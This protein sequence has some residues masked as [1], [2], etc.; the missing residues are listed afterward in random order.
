MGLL[1]RSRHS[2][3]DV[4]ASRALGVVSLAIGLAEILFP[5]KIEQTMGIHNGENTG[6][7]RVLGV[8][9]IAHGIDLLAHD[10][11]TPGVVSRVA[12]DM[13]DGVLLSAAAKKSRNPKGMAL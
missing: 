7:L 8:R 6:M 13:L 11:P 4:A 1:R 12:G 9:E 10:N 5:K 2:T 3:G